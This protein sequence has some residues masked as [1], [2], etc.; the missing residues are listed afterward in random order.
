MPGDPVEPVAFDV[1]AMIR[2]PKPRIV[3]G[4]IQ[5]AT[6]TV[7]DSEGPAM[8]ALL[9]KRS[10]SAGVGRIELRMT[11]IA[12]ASENICAD[13][14]NQCYANGSMGSALASL[15]L[16]RGYT[17][18][19]GFSCTSLSFT[20]GK[21]RLEKLMP[22]GAVWSDMW[23]GVLAA[24]ASVTTARGGKR[25]AMLTPYIAEVADNNAAKMRDHGYTVVRRLDFGFTED[26][27]T[28]SISPDSLADA[29]S[30]LA[31]TEGDVDVVFIGCS[32]FRACEP[33]FITALEA[34]L[35]AQQKAT[36]RGPAVITSTQA[37]LWHMLRH[38]GGNDQLEEY[39]ELFRTC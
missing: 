34:R 38:T 3:L 11:K 1:D 19:Y 32:A 28:A 8:A 22:P 33:G 35:Q 4:V 20:I 13:T 31:G 10:T 5:I 39:G 23:Q 9:N 29:A 36:A 37:F 27:I 17:T 25:V 6:D 12:M 26:A 18:A 15:Q 16:P 7:M 2:L 24:M 14:Y 30:T 21:E